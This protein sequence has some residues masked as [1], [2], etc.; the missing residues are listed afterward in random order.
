MAEV[1]DRFFNIMI[2]DFIEI[3][4]EWILQKIVDAK[5][6]KKA[7]SY[8][9]DYVN[10]LLFVKGKNKPDLSQRLSNIIRNSN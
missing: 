9:R 7:D 10:F 4:K 1:I 3:K 8:T 2:I 6:S 5:N